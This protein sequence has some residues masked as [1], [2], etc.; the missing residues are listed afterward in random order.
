[1]LILDVF[2]EQ[3]ESF[4]RSSFDQAGDQKSIDG[5]VGFVG[6]YQQIQLPTVISRTQFAE[7]YTPLLE[8]FENHLKMLEFLGDDDGHFLREFLAVD[9]RTQ[10]AHRSRCRLVLAVGMVDQNLFEVLVDLTKPPYL[11][12]ALQMEHELLGFVL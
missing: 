5:A 3:F 2:F 1:L 8:Q 6:P 11:G 9:I 10:Q 12:L 7:P 4:A